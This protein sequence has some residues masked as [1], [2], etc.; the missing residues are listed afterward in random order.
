M[1]DQSDAKSVESLEIPVWD[2]NREKL[3]ETWKQFLYKDKKYLPVVLDG[4]FYIIDIEKEKPI[5][6]MEIRMFGTGSDITIANVLIKAGIATIEEMASAYEDGSVDT[7]IRK[8]GNLIKEQS[9]KETHEFL[10]SKG[11]TSQEFYEVAQDMG[12]MAIG[13][14]IADL[15]S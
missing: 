1:T 12:S 6:S 3:P 2:G 15:L 14:L 8:F 7:L 13:K 10:K 4:D 5:K 9:T 11:I